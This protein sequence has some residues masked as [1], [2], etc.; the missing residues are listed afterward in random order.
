MRRSPAL[1]FTALSLLSLAV[2]LAA[3]RLGGFTGFP[4][5]D[6]W[7][8][9]TYA[10][11]LA[12]LGQ[13]AF[14][15]GQPSA[16]STSPLWTAL[17]ALGYLLRIEYHV[18]TYALGG[19]LLALNAWLAYRL[20][21]DLWPTRPAAALSA[22]LFVALEWHLV[23]AAASGMETLLFSALAL[24]VFVTS[25]QRPALAG[26]CVGLSVLARPDGLTLLPFALA[27]AFARPRPV[28]GLLAC[29][30]AFAVVFAPYLVFNYLLSGAIWPNTFYAKQ[31]EYAALLAAPL[32]TRLGRVGLLPF[33]GATA[34]LAPGL[35]A[36][37]LRWGRERRWGA[38]LPLGWVGVFVAA[39]AVRLPVTYQHGRYL[40]PVIP[41]L[42]AVGVGGLSELLRLRAPKLLPRVLS[43]VWALAA[44]LVLLVFLGAG[45]QAYGRDVAIIET[46]MV[47]AARWVNVH[48]PP[49]ALIAAHD[50][51]AL[52]YFGGRPILDLAGLV[53]P[54]VIPFLRDESRL[55]DWLAASG[56]DYLVTFPGWY[57]GLAARLRE[58]RVFSTGAVFSPA[59]GGENMAV[60]ALPGR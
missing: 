11:N 41:I 53:S 40:I 22:G 51:G 10:R 35:V 7:I 33:V 49:G 48:T 25:R 23:W 21:L 36:A 57:P 4:L 12:T 16:G 39:Y 38:L 45:A 42:C 43:R 50:I 55:W 52:G 60:F 34:L 30:A 37:A 13:F 54:Q 9:Q 31:A 29:G 26:W 47:A 3:A 58:A 32:L 1:A 19:A 8:H 14:V 15:L 59:A 28:R 56:A 5:D 46:E 2:Y 20:A 18:W 6:A 24:A 44:A 27:R 17:L